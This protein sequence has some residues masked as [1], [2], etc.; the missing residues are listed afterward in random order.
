MFDLQETASFLQAT[1]KVSVGISIKIFHVPKS[2]LTHELVQYILITWVNISTV[3]AISYKILLCSWSAQ[4]H[5]VT[6]AYVA[7]LNVKSRRARTSS[8]PD[9]QIEMNC[10]NS[11]SFP[12]YYSCLSRIRLDNYFSVKLDV[13]T[14]RYILFN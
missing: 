7:D 2:R 11:L 4:A 1:R 6:W 5:A 3:Y 8:W 13:L 12:L 14:V 10:R 9:R